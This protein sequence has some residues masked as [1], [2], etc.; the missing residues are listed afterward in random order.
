MSG[1]VVNCLLQNTIKNLCEL[2]KNPLNPS[3]IPVPEVEP[4]TGGINDLSESTFVSEY[5]V[6]TGCTHP[7]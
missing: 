3:Y 4:G 5:K 1:T 7:F 2:K 6:S